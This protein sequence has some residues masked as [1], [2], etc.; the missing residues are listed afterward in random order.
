[1][2]FTKTSRQ[3]CIINMQ[4]NNGLLIKSV[5]STFRVGCMKDMQEVFTFKLPSYC[6]TSLIPP[7][8]NGQIWLAV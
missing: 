5:F 2:N 8:E 6:H 4:G 1:M 3:K 7:P